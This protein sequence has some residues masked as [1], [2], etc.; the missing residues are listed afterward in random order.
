MGL[1]DDNE[2]GGESGDDEW[3]RLL[4]S[5]P[6][7]GDAGSTSSS[8]NQSFQPSSFASSPT[9]DSDNAGD[10]TPAP[11]LSS[12]RP[13]RKLL[14]F[15]WNRAPEDTRKPVT[16]DPPQ[17]ATKESEKSPPRH[18]NLPGKEIPSRTMTL[19]GKEV[20]PRTSP[21]PGKES[22]TI[23]VSASVDELGDSDK[24]DGGVG[25][26]KLRWLDSDG[27]ISDLSA[28]QPEGETASELK[29]PT[30][31]PSSGR[32]TA[33]KSMP[34]R[35][36]KLL[37][38]D[39]I[40]SSAGKRPFLSGPDL[41]TAGPPPKLMR[42][43]SEDRKSA[44]S[45]FSDGRESPA[46]L[47]E[48]NEPPARVTEDNE[49]PAPLTDNEGRVCDMEQVIVNF[50]SVGATYAR[51]LHGG[52]L[53]GNI[54][55]DWEGVRQC[56]RFLRDKLGLRVTGVVS[57]ALHGPDMGSKASF[58]LPFDIR[59]MCQS[60]E[61]AEDTP[62]LGSDS[63]RAASLMVAQLAYKTNCRLISD[64]TGDELQRLCDESCRTWLRSC[65]R[66]LLMRYFFN[67]ESGTFETPDQ[68][69]PLAS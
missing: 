22:A 3:Q 66:L 50:T 8:L 20:P 11:V 4:G 67:R 15:G 33:V 27:N 7:A 43:L 48:D 14:D 18:V 25:V 46:P 44:S 26:G 16:K 40:V 56:V 63:R 36:P 41:D 37:P 17:P 30:R 38:T 47:M 21:V 23:R 9:A 59:M 60:V 52:S 35:P 10:S 6:K 58:S 65:R 34:F 42:V 53:K 39:I 62:S 2:S 13:W 45:P 54:C 64:N 68:H 1:L 32:P 49:P 5:A 12:A 19:P 29:P 55:F 28:E 24:E 51:T 69:A 57:E 61:E 31:L